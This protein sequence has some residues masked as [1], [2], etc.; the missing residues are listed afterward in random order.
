MLQNVMLVGGTS[1]G[2]SGFCGSFN[3]FESWQRKCMLLF[4]F[5]SRGLQ[6]RVKTCLG[7][8]KCSILLFLNDCKYINGG[9]WDG[10]FVCFALC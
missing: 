6:Y 2:F 3:T 7:V 8:V 10:M 5:V 4:E 1:Y 9:I